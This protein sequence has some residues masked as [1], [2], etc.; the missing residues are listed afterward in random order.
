M[1]YPLR[2]VLIGKPVRCKG[3][4]NAFVLQTDGT[5][6]KVEGN[7]A[8]APAAANPAPT[9]DP[10]PTR[11]EQLAEFDIDDVVVPMVSPQ[12]PTAPPPPSSSQSSSRPTTER[13]SRRTKS[14][15]L[16]SARLKMAAELAAVASKAAESETV[17]REER[18]KSARLT[19][20]GPATGKPA[21]EKHQ[22][23]RRAVLTGE[24][25]RKHREMLLWL[26]GVGVVALALIIA[27]VI[28]NM[29]SDVRLAL[30]QYADA[31]PASNSF[32][33]K[34]GNTIR[35]RAWLQSAPSMPTGPFLAFDVSDASLL[36]ERTIDLRPIKSV[37]AE[38]AGL[39]LHDNLD[40]WVA[41]ADR[42]KLIALVADQVGAKAAAIA[43]TAQLRVVVHQD[44]QTRLGLTDDDARIIIDL[45]LGTPRSGDN[46][47]KLTDPGQAPDA[48]LLRPFRGRVGDLRKDPGH[49]PYVPVTGK[50]SGLMLSFVGKGWPTT[51][52]VLYLTAD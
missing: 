14:D 25:D 23:Q 42:S 29:R 24:G 40:L 46:F 1:S 35:S 32:Y 34:L 8:A 22:S 43:K 52:R 11:A 21:G 50:Y 39:R 18:Q 27:L 3:C 51:W 28:F 48:I 45:L 6:A 17:K 4:R 37:L 49:P 36:A 44:W 15:H 30:D 5:A 12:A 10:A 41:D 9:R 33:P 19:K 2:P 31:V 7:L 20:A 38:V 16:E 13:S 26:A 47:S